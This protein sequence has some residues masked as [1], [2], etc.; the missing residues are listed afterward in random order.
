MKRL[1]YSVNPHFVP[2]LLIIFFLIVTNAFIFSAL[3]WALVVTLVAALTV[4]L[5]VTFD[6]YFTDDFAFDFY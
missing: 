5:F 3:V 1:R 6:Y 2:Q 4:A